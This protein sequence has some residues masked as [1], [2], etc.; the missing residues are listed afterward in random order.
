MEK[1]LNFMF[2][3]LSYLL[4]SSLGLAQDRDTSSVETSIEFA[5][6]LKS[7]QGDGTVFFFSV[8]YSGSVDLDFLRLGTTR[9]PSIGV[10]AGVEG[11]HTGG[12]GGSIGGSPYLD[13]NGLLRFTLEGTSLRLDGFV[14]YAYHTSSFPQ[15]Y[16]SEGLVKY[17][18]ELRWKIA[19][20][21][22]GMLIK[23][24]GTKS[25]GIFGVGFYFGWDK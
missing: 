7:I 1:W 2:T 16:R 8:S 15:F 14:G 25:A 9:H 17:G 12:P 6:G 5:P 4:L 18:A 24:N 3:I 10:R 11:F 23:A 21:V 20:H 22:F 19:P 13:Y